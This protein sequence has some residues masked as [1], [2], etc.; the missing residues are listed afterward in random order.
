LVVGSFQLAKTQAQISLHGSA[1]NP[2]TK[3]RRKEEDYGGERAGIYTWRLR[4]S[5]GSSR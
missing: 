5:H 3:I 1:Y 2:C 4:V